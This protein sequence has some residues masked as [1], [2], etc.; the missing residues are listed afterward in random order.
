MGEISEMMLDGTLCAMC[1]VA[2][3]HDAE[4]EE[5][6]FPMYCSK[7]CARDAGITDKDELKVLVKS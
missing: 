3:L 1:G 6:G 4:E 7:Q 5:A 2:L